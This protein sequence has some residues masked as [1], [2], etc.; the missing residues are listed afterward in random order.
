VHLKEYIAYVQAPHAKVLHRDGV[1]DGAFERAVRTALEEEGYMVD[2]CVGTGIYTIDLAIRHPEAP[3]SYLLGI[4]SDGRNYA[5]AATARDRHRLRREMLEEVMGW[6]LQR[7][8]SKPWAEH[9][10]Q[11]LESLQAKIETLLV[12]PTPSRVAVL[13]SPASPATIPHLDPGAEAG[14]DPPEITL[15]SDDG[16][17]DALKTETY[18]AYRPQQ[19]YTMDQYYEDDA[20]RDATVLAIVR[21]EEPVH[22]VVLFER[23][24]TVFGFSRA[25]AKFKQTARAT[26]QRLAN[27]GELIVDRSFLSTRRAHADVAPRL[28]APGT[29]PRRLYHI[30]IAEIAE[31]CRQI[32]GQ[33]YGI[34]QEALARQ[35]TRVFGHHVLT[36]SRKACVLEAIRWLETQGAV[37]VNNEYVFL[38]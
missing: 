13:P 35:V 3:E 10:H 2:S 29:E 9:P 16:W 11:A 33:I 8:W 26:L 1:A 37:V 4:E 19:P 18:V 31:L 32:C 27:R 24:E 21:V 20:L 6:R 30:C 36:R 5:D 17:Q 28:P 15:V 23:L 34:H 12:T 25:T 38:A 14:S 7:I 22:E